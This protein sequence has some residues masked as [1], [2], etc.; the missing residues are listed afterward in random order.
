MKKFLI[1]LISLIAVS[2]VAFFALN[3][4]IYEEKQGD[5]KDT[6]PYEATLTGEQVCLPHKDTRGPQTLECAF[7]MKLDTGE[8]YALDF[9]RSPQGI[10]TLK[11]GDRFKATGIV[12]PIEMLS[13]DQWKKYDIQGIFSITSAL[14]VL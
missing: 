3:N 4:Y 13:S 9:N 8:Y 2:V 12:T 10:T 11:T 14:E 1:T 5:P 7:G 6:T